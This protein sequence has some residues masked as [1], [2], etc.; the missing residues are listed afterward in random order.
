MNWITV[1]WSAVAGASL[2]M[3]LMHLLIWC[4]DRSSWANL[5]FSINVVG[6]LG[7]AAAEMACLRTLSPVEYGD[8]VRWGHLAFTVAFVG[9]VLFVHFYFGTGR[10]W[11]LALALGVRLLATVVN[12]MSGMNLHIRAIERLERITLLGEPVTV[13]AKWQPNP[14][15]RLGQ[16][17]ALLWL[18]AWW[19]L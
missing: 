14:W 17:A 15:M 19:A 2:A 6:V 18:A 1:I 13:L 12:F 4:R 5:C 9:S 3:A 10:R 16:F 8:A 11:L 7:L